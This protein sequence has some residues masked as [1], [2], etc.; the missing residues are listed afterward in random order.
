MISINQSINQ[1]IPIRLFCARCIINAYRCIALILIVLLAAVVNAATN[2]APVL[3]PPRRQTK[4]A[5]PGNV[6]LPRRCQKVLGGGANSLLTQPSLHWQN[7]LWT[8]CHVIRTQHHQPTTFRAET[9][10]TKG[11]HHEWVNSLTA[12]D[13]HKHQLFN[14]FLRCFVSSPIFVRCQR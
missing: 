3:H 13:T 7:S 6:P 9:I 12:I 5:H 8:W 11:P 14:K 2:I 10:W 4:T 1:L